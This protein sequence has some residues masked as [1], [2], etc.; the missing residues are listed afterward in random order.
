MTKTDMQPFPTPTGGV[1]PILTYLD[2]AMGTG[3]TC[4]PDLNRLIAWTSQ[5]F[6]LTNQGNSGLKVFLVSIPSCNGVSAEAVR[7]WYMLF[8]KMAATTGFYLHILNITVTL[9][10]PE[11]S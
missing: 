10:T 4:Q 6:S 2:P 3:F 7:T 9:S 5:F 8:I 1:Y 11:P